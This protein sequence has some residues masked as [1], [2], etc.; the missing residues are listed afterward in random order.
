M[1]NH[2]TYNNFYIVQF[3]SLKSE[4]IN[5]RPLFYILFYTLNLTP[6]FYTLVLPPYF[7]SLFYAFILHPFL[8][9]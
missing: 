9:L 8:Q 3:Y 6:L 2:I 7:M 4:T 1:T 5:S